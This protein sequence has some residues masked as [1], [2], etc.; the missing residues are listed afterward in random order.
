MQAI[1][2]P[3]NTLFFTLGKILTF[4]GFF[5]IFNKKLVKRR[6]GMIIRYNIQK[7]Q[8]MISDF[9]NVTK[10]Q[11]TVLDSE[12]NNLTKP[13]GSTHAFCQRIQACAGGEEKCM[14]SDIALLEECRTKNQP[15]VHLCHA[16]LFDI[17]TPI[18]HMQEN[19]VMG[20]LLMGRCR[21][22]TD[23][24]Q[25][26][27]Y[28]SHFPGS[29]EDWEAD[30]LALPYYTDTTIRSAARL[31]ASISVS[32]LQ[33]NLIWL[34]LNELAQAAATFIS[35][36]LAEDLSLKRLCKELNV[37]KNVLYN[38]FHSHFGCTVNAY[39]T[40]ER[41]R[42]AKSLLT[43]SSMP[44]NQICENVGLKATTYFCKMFREQ[45][46]VTPLVY[47]KQRT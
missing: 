30:Y 33:D 11:I 15:I 12:L 9:Y 2:F 26:A 27:K 38:S 44:I 4:L 29:Y 37:N 1:M 45:T 31:A 5:S 18:V 41:I 40:K 47:R 6:I 23:F 17:A 24:T 3:K 21:H 28:V 43:H 16:G 42:K 19:I 25:V 32:I 13:T 14:Q 8:E 7:L 46:G 36:H 10:I 22:T 39:I 20:Y 35:D 34:E